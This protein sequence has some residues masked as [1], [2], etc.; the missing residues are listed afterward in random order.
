MENIFSSS[1]L[2]LSSIFISFL[3]IGKTWGSNIREFLFA[4]RSL[5]V[6]STGAAISSHWLWAIALFVGPAT[7]YNWGVIGMLTFIIPNALALLVIGGLVNNIRDRYPEGFSLTEYIKT[8]FSKKVAA[9]YQFEFVAVAFAALLLAFTAI[10]KLWAF[11]GLQDLIQPTYAS[12]LF[13]LIT[14]GFTMKGG[15][16]TSVFTGT[17]QAILFLAFFLYAGQMIEWSGLP[18]LSTGKNDLQS[19]FDAKFLTTFAGAW[20]ITIIVGATSHGGLW[21]KAF[22]MPKENVFESFAIGSVIFALT[23]AGLLTLAMFAFA[24]GLPVTS[25]D[26]AAVTAIRDFLGPVALLIFGT[27][28]IGQT[29]TVIDSSMNYMASLV[30]LEWL[31]KDQVWVSRLVMLVFVLL[32]WIV[33]WAKLEIWTVLMLMGAV[34]TV[35]FVP[36]MLHIFDVKLSERLIFVV[37]IVTI[38]CAFTLAWIAKMDKLPIYDLYSASL[39]IGAPLVLY[40]SYKLL[41]K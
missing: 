3:F 2:F 4:N 18:V 13:G 12:L 29:S 14:L 25:P 34:R 35:M 15:I 7:A 17:I 10:G 8:N 19:L 41:R 30:T 33:S 9:L 26:L 38:P 1:L 22:S 39:A 23:L 37:S 27:I 32:A 31:K 28:F 11:A 36:L 21:Q 24:N 20:V 16:R 40:G 6:V 5:K